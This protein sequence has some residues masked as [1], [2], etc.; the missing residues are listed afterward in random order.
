VNHVDYWQ[1]A[2]ISKRRWRSF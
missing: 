1:S 2:V